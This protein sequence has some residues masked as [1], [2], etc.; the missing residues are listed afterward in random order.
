MVGE[1]KVSLNPKQEN[2]QLHLRKFQ[3]GNSSRRVQTHRPH[4]VGLRG[5]LVAS[6]DRL[7]LQIP[8]K[9]EIFSM[10]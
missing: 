1:L 9:A 8:L 3:R 7:L 4:R 5:S 2:L 6:V 10:H